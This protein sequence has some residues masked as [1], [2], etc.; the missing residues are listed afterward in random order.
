[1]MIIGLVFLSALLESSC[2][3]AETLKRAN[4]DTRTVALM[5]RYLKLAICYLRNCD[6]QRGKEKLAKAL[7]IEPKNAD[8]QGVYGLGFHLGGENDLAEG[9]FRQAVRY[10]PQSARIQNSYVRFL[11][12]E[13]R[14][15]EVVAHLSNASED[16][17]AV[18]PGIGKYKQYKE[19]I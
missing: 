9:Y 8:L 5:E 6:Y 14:F 10:G 13:K 4:I 1:M 3:S 18:Y 15:H 2:Q 7:E 16:L 12:S 17:E 11:F 19:S